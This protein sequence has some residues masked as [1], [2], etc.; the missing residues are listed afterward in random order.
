MKYIADIIFDDE[1]DFI[2]EAGEKVLLDNPEPNFERG[3]FIHIDSD[4]NPGTPGYENDMINGLLDT[5]DGTDWKHVTE[6]IY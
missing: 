5:F 4:Y 3:R 1:I 2:K 6:M